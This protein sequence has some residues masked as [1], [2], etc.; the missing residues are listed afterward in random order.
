MIPA[1]L[2]LCGLLALVAGPRQAGVPRYAAAMLDGA[3][4][5]QRVRAEVQ[6]Q[7]GG[8]ARTEQVGRDARLVFRSRSREGGLAVEAW[9]DSLHL[10][11]EGPEGRVTPDADP[12]IGGRYRGQLD[13]D[14][15]LRIEVRPFVPDEL[16]EV[17][18]LREALADFLPRLPPVA[19]AA[20]G[21]WEAG[22]WR[23]VRRP[24]SAAGDARLQRY[25]WRRVAADTVEDGLTDSLRYR[26]R[27]AVEEEGDLVWHATLGP[28]VWHRRSTTTLEIPADGPVRRSARTRMREEAWVW[29]RLGGG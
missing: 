27:S 4:F 28:L 7:S 19:L 23:I 26:V 9:F 14:G 11:R 13:P 17:T 2:A 24:D 5:D 22:G 21:V 10:W 6:T 29:R 15:T 16:L 1:R 20:G 8:S 3:A 25:R 12:V 18:D